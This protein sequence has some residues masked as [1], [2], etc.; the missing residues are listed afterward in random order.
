[1]LTRLL[2]EEAAHKLS[3]ISHDELAF[4]VFIVLRVKHD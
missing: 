4:S 1:M 3:L 2:F